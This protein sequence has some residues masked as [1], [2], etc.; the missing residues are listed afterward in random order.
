MKSADFT[1]FTE[2]GRDTLARILR[3]VITTN[4]ATSE[5]LAEALGSHVADRLK[6][7]KVIKTGDESRR[8]S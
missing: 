4:A 7:S 5:S 8:K 3:R 2:Q 6:R 1:K